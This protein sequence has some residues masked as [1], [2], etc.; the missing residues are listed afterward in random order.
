MKTRFLYCQER[1]KYIRESRALTHL[2]STLKAGAVRL[3]SFFGEVLKNTRDVLSLS[4]GEKDEA[5]SANTLSVILFQGRL[6]ESGRH[7]SPTR[8]QCIKVR[9]QPPFFPFGY[10]LER[11]GGGFQPVFPL[12]P[13]EA[14]LTQVLFQHIP[15]QAAIGA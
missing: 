15:P 9:T 1:P 4:R 12:R 6:Q 11:M 14:G 8:H 7:A 3:L 2:Q 10:L 5:R 13:K